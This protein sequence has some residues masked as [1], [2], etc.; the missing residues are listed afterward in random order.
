M[1]ENTKEIEMI[2]ILINK[3][4]IAHDSADA[5]R[6]S[7]AAVNAANAIRCLADI[8]ENRG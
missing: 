2:S 3:A 7:Q 6:F 5:Q 1:N 8:K 4:S